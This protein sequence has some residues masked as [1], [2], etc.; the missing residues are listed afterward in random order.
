MKPQQ[1]NTLMLY[2]YML[3]F[4]PRG[5]TKHLYFF[6]QSPTQVSASGFLA[7]EAMANA[8]A[9]LSA[10]AAATILLLGGPPILCLDIIVF[11]S[12]DI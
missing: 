2:I 5:F 3:L 8:S 12:L 4:E 11:L 7:M 9:I 6:D 1:N 10:R